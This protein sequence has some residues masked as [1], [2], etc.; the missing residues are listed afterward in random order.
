MTHQTCPY[1]FILGSVCLWVVVTM[2]KTEEEEIRSTNDSLDSFWFYSV[3]LFVLL[4]G[5]PPPEPKVPVLTPIEAANRKV[6][7]KKRLEEPNV[8]LLCAFKMWS[9]NDYLF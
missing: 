5:V 9:E 8:L 3:S 1:W 2:S 6:K 7:K 4:H